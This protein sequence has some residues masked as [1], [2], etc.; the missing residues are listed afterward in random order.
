MPPHQPAN[1]HLAPN[2]AEICTLLARGLLRLRSRIADESADTAAESRGH[3]DIRLHS[4][5]PQRRHAN[6]TNRRLA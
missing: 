6:R 3:G 5:A 4:T 1:P 2:L